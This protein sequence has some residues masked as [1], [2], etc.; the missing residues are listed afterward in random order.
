MC[1]IVGYIG[2]GQ[3][4]EYVIEG[5]Q[6]LEYR[7]Y[8]SAGFA[9]LTGDGSIAWQKAVGYL[10]NLKNKLDA[11]PIDGYIGIGHTRWATHGDICEENAHPHIDCHGTISVVHNGIIENYHTLKNSLISAGHRFSS[12]TDTEVIAHLCESIAYDTMLEDIQCIVKQL[13]GAYSFIAISKKWPNTVIAV[14][15]GSPLCAGIAP[16]GCFLAS[17]PFAF[18]K[19]T[20]E[21]ISLPDESI[22]LVNQQGTLLYDFNGNQIQQKKICIEY[23][24]YDN[25]KSGYDH[26]MLKEIYEQKKAIHATLQHC[27]SYETGRASVLNISPETMSSLKTIY[28]IGAGTSWHAGRI[29]QFFFEHLCRIP[30]RVVLA[31]EFRYGHFFKEESAL[32]IGISQS[33][34]TADTLE[35]MRMI[36]NL[37]LPTLALANVATSTMVREAHGY[38]LTKAGQEIAVASTKAFSTQLVALYWLSVQI[39][40][41]KK[42]LQESDCLKLYDDILITAEVLENTIEHYKRD[43][44]ENYAPFYAQFQRFIFLGR[45]ISYPFAME[46]ALKLKEISYIFSQCYPAGELKHGP[47]ALLDSKTPVILFSNLESAIYDK[48]VSN[49]EEI[50]A[51]KTHLIVYAFEGQSELMALADC[52]FVLPRVNPLLAPLAMTGLMQFFVYHIAKV[53]GCPIDKPRNLAKSVTVE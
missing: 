7:G 33:G 31:S 28:L 2:Y 8:D 16:K 39:A 45:H 53:L 10:K 15:K 30:V 44:V 13:R 20:S 5:L 11:Y 48:V 9:C 12:K 17:D 43:I 42:L 50:K 21:M 3:S 26:F 14:R 4:R 24:P 23:D 40:M 49:A 52:A 41:H 35:C 32:Y 37:G 25:E 27:R 22:V 51:R 38:I 6:R 36:N 19:Y 47:I 29:G 1:G 18:A 34:E 46:A